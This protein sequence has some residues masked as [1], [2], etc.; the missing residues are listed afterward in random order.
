MRSVLKPGKYVCRAQPPVVHISQNTCERKTPL[1]LQNAKI[2][3]QSTQNNNL[4]VG[5]KSAQT[6][7]RRNADTNYD[8]P[9]E[10]CQHGRK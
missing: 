1:P 8:N 5:F 6:E 4:D 2:G 7:R 9:V 3:T 10:V